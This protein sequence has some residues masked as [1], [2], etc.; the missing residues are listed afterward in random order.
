MI[1]VSRKTEFAIRGMIYLAKQPEGEFVIIRDIARAAD[2]T[3]VFLAKIFQMLS[4]AGLV[5]SSRG[6]VGGFKLSRVPEQITLRDIVEAIE[7]PVYVNL[8]IMDD[9][10]CGLTKTCSVHKTWKRV[11]WI[12]DILKGVTLQEVAFPR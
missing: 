6:A 7:G 3:P 5:I 9:G 11:R 1:R 10:V 8:C 4:G 2:T 12:N